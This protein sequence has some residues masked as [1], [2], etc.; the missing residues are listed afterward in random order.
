[1]ADKNMDRLAVIIGMEAYIERLADVNHGLSS[2]E[3]MASPSN[4]G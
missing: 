4:C 3:M 2:L 1:M